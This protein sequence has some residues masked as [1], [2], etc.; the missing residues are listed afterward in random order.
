MLTVAQ[1]L[2]KVLEHAKPL[3]VETIALNRATGRTL[4]SDLK[5]LRTQPPAAVS[6]MDGYALRAVDA[7]FS[8]RLAVI[9]AAPAGTPFEG[10]VNAGEA[11]R[12]FT[13]A[14]VPKGADAVLIQEN[15]TANNLTIQ[16][17]EAA[18]RGDNI[19]PAVSG[20][21]DRICRKKC[22]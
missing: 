22:I 15:V 2:A 13:G 1:A 19:R 9:G 21:A 5:A 3:G 7:K 10:T 18:H 16:V 12:I 11:C 4:A 8:A 17:N 6:A 14:V 20:K